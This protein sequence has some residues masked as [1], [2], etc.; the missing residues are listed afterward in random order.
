MVQKNIILQIY[1]MCCVLLPC[2]CYQGIAMRRSGTKKYR[3]RH[4]LWS[5]LFCLYLGMALQVAG[6]GTIWDVDWTGQ[7]IHMDEINLIPFQSEGI[8]TYILN[9]IMFLPFGFLLPLIWRN[10]RAPASVLFMGMGFSAAIEVCQLF[11][12]RTT[13]ID[14]LLMNTL[15]TILGYLIWRVF[16]KLYPASGKKKGFVSVHEPVWYLVLSVLGVFL[17]Y[18]WK[19]V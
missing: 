10:Y 19:W 12:H 1:R 5:I 14:D 18:N 13:D 11:N 17:F 6:I 16:R 15:G 4:L 9:V 7:I 8:L 3:I 2:L